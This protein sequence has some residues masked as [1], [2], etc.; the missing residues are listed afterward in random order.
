[1]ARDLYQKRSDRLLST[2]DRTGY[3]QTKITGIVSQEHYFLAILLCLVSLDL[4]TYLGEHS[5]TSHGSLLNLMLAGTLLLNW[6][7]SQFQWPRKTTAWFRCSAW[8]GSVAVLLEAL[9]SIR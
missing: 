5:T 2:A 7:A 3:K 6:L 9:I 1:M 4:G 8:A